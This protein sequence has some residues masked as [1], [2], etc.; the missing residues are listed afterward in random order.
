MYPGRRKEASYM[1]KY[2]QGRGPFFVQVPLDLLEDP[3]IDA[4]AI[5]VYCSLRSFADF[6]KATGSRPSDARAAKLAGCSERA[7]R[8]RRELLRDRGWIEWEQHAGRPNRYTIH[9]SPGTPAPDAVVDTPAGGADL[10]RHEVPTTPARGADLPRH[11][12]P[13][14]ENQY[15]EPEP[16]KESAPAKAGTGD[17]ATLELIAEEPKPK[18]WSTQ[19]IDAWAA[20]FPGGLAPAGIIVGNLKRLVTLHGEAEVLNRWRHYLT[21]AP[22]QF[23]NAGTF[24]AKFSEYDPANP[25]TQENH[26]GRANGRP[27]AAARG[28]AGTTPAAGSKYDKRIIRGDTGEALDG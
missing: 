15:R 19:A 18:A 5:A 6:G 20:R 11:E 21:S 24:A 2:E 16:I 7:L 27:A 10:P 8:S 23:A 3:T 9:S 26:R 17:P 4:V 13:T 22:A 14:T 25:T 1:A 12:V 28:P